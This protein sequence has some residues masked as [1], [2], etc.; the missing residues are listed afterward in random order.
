MK[1]L[2]LLGLSAICLLGVSG[3]VGCNSTES[4]VINIQFVPSN[5]A[6]T[7]AALS[8][9]LEPVLEKICPDYQFKITTGTSYAATTEALLSDQVDVGFLTASG[10]AQATIQNPGKIEVKLT[11]VRKGYKVQVEDYK[12]D[13][14]N[15]IKAM[16]G[17][18]SGYEYLGQQSEQDVNWYTSQLCVTNANYVDKNSDGKIDIKDMAGLKIGRMG[19]TSGAGYLRPLKYLNDNGME[20]VDT[21]TDATKQIQGVQQNSYGDAFN[22]MQSGTIDGF[23]GF[24]DVRYAQGY[25][26]SDSAYYQLATSF[27]L[28]K[29]VAIT[30]GIYNDTISVRSNLTDA[31]K[32]AVVKAFKTAIK[33]TN[34]IDD[35][36]TESLSPAEI[37]YKV[38]SH[39]GYTDAKD[40][41]FD[42]E[43]EFYNYCVAND[44]I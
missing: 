14:E 26:K 15:Q 7:L 33:D 19:A 23:W 39:T 37:L 31:K 32:E 43:R 1:K 20:M 35:G 5:D 4:N 6:S 27:T 29:C 8:K 12:D 16:N 34:K 41:D 44:L 40:S 13:V 22:N 25:T 30:D 17:E 28:S 9:R 38:Y 10:Y 11:S 42:G 36:A 18:I 2:N 21:I 24:T 3:L